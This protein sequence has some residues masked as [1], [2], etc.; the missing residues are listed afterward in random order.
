MS[1]TYQLITI[2]DIFDKVPPD[3]IE[4]CMREIATAMLYTKEIGEFMGASLGWKE[5]CEW[6]DDG[7]EDQTIVIND[8]HGDHA[9]TFK[10]TKS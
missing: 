10:A 6:I 9:L 1:N 4:T 7:K 3:R 8:Q 5:P 2:K